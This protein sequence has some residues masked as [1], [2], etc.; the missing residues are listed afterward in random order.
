MTEDRIFAAQVRQDVTNDE[1]LRQSLKMFGWHSE[2][3]AIADESGAVLVGNRRLR[4]AKE[5]GIEPIIKTINFGNGDEADA[6][7]LKLALIS[8]LGSQPLS[9]DDRRRI[10]EHLYG[11]KGW[12]M[13]RIGE[14]LGVG[15]RQ[16]SRDLEGLDTMSKPPRPRG[17]RPRQT[18][19]KTADVVDRQERIIAFADAGMSAKEISQEV[20][21][22]E[23]MVD[24]V[25]E[26]EGARREGLPPTINPDLLSKSAQEKLAAAIKTHKRMLDREFEVRVLEECRKRLDELSLPAHAKQ[27]EEAQMLLRSRHKG[28][29]PRSIFQLI[30][31]CLHSDSRKSV[32]DKKLDQ[33][34]HEFSTRERLFLSE[35]DDP[36]PSL[37]FP[38][39]WAEAQEWK[40]KVKES[41]KTKKQAMAR[42]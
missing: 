18:G 11:E 14:A 20:G 21:V 26:V 28:I 32:T 5:E 9:K 8:N 12:T 39:T 34:F 2:F 15:Q 13:Q 41:R 7:R 4:I 40:R 22:G 25:L 38:R 24:R 36:T 37:K 30:R 1:E 10:A 35:E 16:I 29:M 31:S 42:I 19:R 17:G 3:P 23:R 33:A 6:S 27:V